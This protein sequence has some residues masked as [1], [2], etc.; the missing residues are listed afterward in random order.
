[1]TNQARRFIGQ[2][3]SWTAQEGDDAEAEGPDQPLI[4][5]TCQILYN[6]CLN[7]LLLGALDAAPGL[8]GM[9]QDAAVIRILDA[10]D[11]QLALLTC[12][13][14]VVVYGYGAPSALFPAAT[15][16][17]GRQRHML[18]LWAAAGWVLEC[19]QD[20]GQEHVPGECW[21][22]GRHRRPLAGMRRHLH[23]ATAALPR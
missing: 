18:E 9:Q 3:W 19:L 2:V 14:E 17:L 5:H 11:M 4:A 12:C 6:H 16:H 10:G 7:S 22:V 20:P 13:V 23:D 15:L 21:V 8:A 1:M